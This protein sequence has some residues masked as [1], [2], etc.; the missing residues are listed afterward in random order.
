MSPAA[1]GSAFLVEASIPWAWLKIKPVSGL[2][3]RGDFGLLAADD[4]GTVTVARHYWSN[5]ST[6]LVNDVP[7]EA[8]LVPQLWGELTLQ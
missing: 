7:G 6:G 1:G 2:K 8:D 4:G 5:K 3:L